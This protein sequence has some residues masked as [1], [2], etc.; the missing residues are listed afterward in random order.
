MRRLALLLLLDGTTPLTAASPHILVL[1][2][3]T[4]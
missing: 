4:K 3:D 1:A 2:D